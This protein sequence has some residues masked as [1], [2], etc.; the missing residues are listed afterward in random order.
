MPVCHGR[1]V[2]L[3]GSY[4]MAAAECTMLHCNEKGLC[5]VAY[6]YTHTWFC[7][8]DAGASFAQQQR[9]RR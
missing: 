4:D 9:Q 2:R 7:A 6:T 5:Q 1:K 3:S 8:I